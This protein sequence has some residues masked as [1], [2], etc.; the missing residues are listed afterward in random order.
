MYY[1]ANYFFFPLSC[2]LG[3]KRNNGGNGEHY[4]V[5]RLPPKGR[6]TA[7]IKLLLSSDESCIFKKMGFGTLVEDKNNP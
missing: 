3:E 5:A 1:L 7:I 6:P 2:K 4:V